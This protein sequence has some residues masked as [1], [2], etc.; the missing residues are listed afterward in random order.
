MIVRVVAEAK[1]LSGLVDR[2]GA[3][4]PALADSAM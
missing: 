2:I 3:T 4:A 1:V